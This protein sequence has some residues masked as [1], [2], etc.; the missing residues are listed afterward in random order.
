MASG[1]TNVNNATDDVV[2]GGP[3]NTGYVRETLDDKDCFEEYDRTGSAK[4]PHFRELHL[5]PYDVRLSV[6]FFL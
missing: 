2:Y 1:S 6:R 5:P 4:R 3:G